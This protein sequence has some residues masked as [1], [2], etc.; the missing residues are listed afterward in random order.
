MATAKILVVEDDDSVRLMLHEGLQRDGF[1]VVSAANVSD[2][3]GHIAS[4]KFDV[5]LSDLH[6]PL[7]GG[8]FTVVGAMRHTHPHAL[9]I[10]LSGYPA[11]EEAMSAIVGHADE[12]LSKPIQISS[13]R[14]L[15]H[16]RLAEPHTMKRV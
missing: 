4:E 8:G 16:A 12:I 14:K 9:T 7:A 3:L 6:M 1:T 11:I 13:I 10:V 15:I 2:A 5:L